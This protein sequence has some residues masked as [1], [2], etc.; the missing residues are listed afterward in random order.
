[1]AAVLGV[2]GHAQRDAEEGLDDLVRLERRAPG[3]LLEAF[4]RAQARLVEPGQAA[5]RSR[6]SGFCFASVRLIKKGTLVSNDRLND[7]FVS[8]NVKPVIRCAAL[9]AVARP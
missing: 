5:A 1:M 6:V 8:G 4:Q 3:F 9:S 2:G 7:T